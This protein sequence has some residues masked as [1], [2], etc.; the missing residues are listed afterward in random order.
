MALLNI[1]QLRS[2][3]NVHLADALLDSVSSDRSRRRT[4]RRAPRPSPHSETHDR[5][6]SSARP[7][8]SD[9]QPSNGDGVAVFAAL[10]ALEDAVAAARVG[11]QDARLALHLKPISRLA[12]R[13]AAVARIRVAVVARLGRRHQTVPA[14]RELG[15]GSTRRVA[16]VALLDEGQFA[17]HPSPGL[18]VA[19][20]ASF[21]LGELTVAAPG[22][23]GASRPAQRAFARRDRARCP[24]RRPS[25]RRRRWYRPSR[26]RCRRYPALDAL[27]RLWGCCRRRRYR[28]RGGNK[29]DIARMISRANQAR[30][31]LTGKTRTAGR[32][33]N[34]F[35][36]FAARRREPPEFSRSVYFQ[37]RG[38][39]SR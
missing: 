9:E 22:G 4:P 25:R 13:R 2:T 6:R 35:R 31:D 28:R 17:A 15:S 18:A 7:R 8:H 37:P 5:P 23:A 12:A 1:S 3:G 32:L 34:R 21:V 26:S 39:N 14:L 29:Q 27:D 30:I 20:V 33:R 16:R 38:T 11:V 19:V 24:C 10:R 36:I